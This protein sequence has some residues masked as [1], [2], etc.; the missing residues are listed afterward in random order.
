MGDGLWGAIHRARIDPDHDEVTCEDCGE[1]FPTET[2]EQRDRLQ[3]GCPN[4]NEVPDDG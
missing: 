1:T 3:G 4:C 2:E